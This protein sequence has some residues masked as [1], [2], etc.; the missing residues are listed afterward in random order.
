[1]YHAAELHEEDFVKEGLQS[2]NEQHFVINLQERNKI[3]TVTSRTLG[4]RIYNIFVYGR[5]MVKN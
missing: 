1:M 4:F 5:C 3:E 2:D